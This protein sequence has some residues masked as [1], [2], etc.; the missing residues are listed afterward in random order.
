[1]N[2]ETVLFLC[3]G[4]SCRSQMAEALLRRYAG[5]RFEVFSAGMEPKDIHPLTR[6][7]LT[8][9]GLDMKGQH[10]KGVE[11]YLGKLLVHYLI[12]VCAKAAESC[13]AAWPGSPLMEVIVWP[14]EDPT[15]FE[16]TETQKL[17]KF[18]QVRDQIDERIKA[19]LDEL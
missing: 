6:Q 11:A 16:G 8:E 2:K 7:I 3:S 15:V 18:R 4:N 17:E 5:E 10:S 12:V 1:M 13:P 14:F 19:W 9:M